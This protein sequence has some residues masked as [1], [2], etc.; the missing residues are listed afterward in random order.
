M[1]LHETFLADAGDAG[2]LQAG[3]GDLVGGAVD[4]AEGD[5]AGLAGAIVVVADHGSEAGENSAGVNGEQGVEAAAFG[6][7]GDAHVGGG[8]PLVPDGG[9]PGDARMIGFAGFEAGQIGGVRNAG[10]DAGDEGGVGEVVVGH[11]IQVNEDAGHVVGIVGFKNVEER[12]DDAFEPVLSGGHVGDVDPLVG[13]LVT[14]DVSPADG[15]ALGVTVAEG[16][17]TAAR[18]TGQ[19]EVVGGGVRDVEAGLSAEDDDVADAVVGENGAELV[20]HPVVKV[21]VAMGWMEGEGAGIMIPV[22]AVG[23]VNSLID[24]GRSGRAEEFERAGAGVGRGGGGAQEGVAR[25]GWF[26][27]IQIP[28]VK[29]RTGLVGPDG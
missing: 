29:Q 20:V 19:G 28:A 26:V 8:G 14:V 15:E 2:K 1:Q 5:A 27:A 24:I 21:K 18:R 16:V 6:T 25:E 23:A 3:D 9:Q 7:D 22:G 11:G 12:V 4:G 10:G 17:M 13:E